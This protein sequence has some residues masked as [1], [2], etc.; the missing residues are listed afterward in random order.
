M[1]LKCLH[2][3]KIFDKKTEFDEHLNICQFIPKS[4]CKSCKNVKLLV[5]KYN[6]Q[7]CIAFHPKCRTCKRCIV[8]NG[9]KCN[10]YNKKFKK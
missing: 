4:I 9:L 2:C 6:C 7:S 1:Y 3:F 10:S 5:S 8:Q